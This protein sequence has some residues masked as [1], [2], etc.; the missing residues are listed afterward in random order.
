[1]SVHSASH[2]VTDCTVAY[3]GNVKPSAGETF[4]LPWEQ[5]LWSCAPAFPARLVHRHVEYCVTDFRLA[6]RHRECTLR[7]MVLDDIDR[8]M[9]TQSWWQRASGA[10]TV[11]VWS[12]RDGRLLRFAN[13]RRGPQLALILQLRAT[14]RSGEDGTTGMDADFFRSVLGPVS[15]PDRHTRRRRLLAA[16]TAAFAV[17][18]VGAGIARQ[19]S[20]PPVV[21]ADDDPIAP[22]GRRRPTAEIVNF[23]EREVMPFARVALAPLVGGAEAV[24]CETCHGKDAE[25]RVWKMPGVR[26]LPEPQLRFGGLERA[27]RP[28]D[29]QIRNAVYGYLAEEDNQVIA[30]YMRREV[31]PGMAKIMRRPAYDFAQSYGFN[32][33][34]RAVGCY[35]C[36]LVE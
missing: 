12:R 24:T 22:H 11:E 2:L 5:R 34:Q 28:L 15:P 10:S 8:V 7:E 30:A 35:H 14:G 36:H 9:V 6:V 13:I 23:M 16:A 27:G 1:V 33:S 17:L 26:A 21:Y 4:P 31:M 19:D 3:I 25:S 18:F 20:L 32:R 29:P